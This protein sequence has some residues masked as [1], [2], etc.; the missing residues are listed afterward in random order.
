MNKVA[1]FFIALTML[2]AGLAAGLNI[3]NNIEVPAILTVVCLGGV[4]ISGA[5]ASILGKKETKS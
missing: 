1:V 3:G 5:I 2:F 4:V